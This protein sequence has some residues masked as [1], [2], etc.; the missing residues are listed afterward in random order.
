VLI[1]DDHSVFR[2]SA[3][4]LLEVAG[5]DVVGEAAD[6]AAALVEAERLD[7]DVVLLDV[8]LPDRDGFAVAD[9]LARSVHPPQVVLISS[10][11]RCDYGRR[12]GRPGVLGFI[13]K[14]DLSRA[15]LE[16]CLHGGG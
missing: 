10:R 16:A 1:V 8:Q 11:E 12:I 15:S 9:D 4:R 14:P 3:R 2:S 6:A 7:P 5:Y 13:H